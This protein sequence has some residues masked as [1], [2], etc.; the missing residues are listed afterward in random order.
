MLE[1][2]LSSETYLNTEDN[3]IKGCIEK[4]IIN[5]FEYKIKRSFDC[6]LA[7]G[8]K[9]FDVAGLR[10]NPEKGFRRGSIQI[11]V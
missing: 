8:V 4:I 11:S 9:Y 6:Y 2:L 5:E 1:G 7:R 10:A 3:T